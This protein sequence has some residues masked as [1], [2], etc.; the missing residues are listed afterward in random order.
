[1]WKKMSIHQARKKLN[2][3]AK[4]EIRKMDRERYPRNKTKR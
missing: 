1:M 2:E 4:E 3:T